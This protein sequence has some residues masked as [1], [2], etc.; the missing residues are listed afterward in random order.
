V[1]S[2]LQ[3]NRAA[4][5]SKSADER[6]IR[7]I[8]YNDTLKHSAGYR[9]PFFDPAVFTGFD[10]GE[11]I[12]WSMVYQ[13]TLPYRSRNPEWKPGDNSLKGVRL[14]NGFNGVICNGVNVNEKGMKL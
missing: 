1:I 8:W 14:S 4:P 3:V 7:V 6:Q 2:L 13:I 12:L 5:D 9:F 10:M 11:K